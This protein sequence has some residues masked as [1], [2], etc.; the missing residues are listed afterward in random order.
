MMRRKERTSVSTEPR[1]T[2]SHVQT[3]KGTTTSVATK[4]ILSALIT[5]QFPS[6]IDQNTDGQHQSLVVIAGNNFKLHCSSPVESRFLWR[7]C[8]LGNRQWKIVYNGK[9]ITTT[10]Q[11]AAKVSVSHCGVTNC[12]FNVVNIQ[13]AGAG[14]FT[15]MGEPYNKYW[16]VTILSKYRLNYFALC[17]SL[18]GH[19]GTWPST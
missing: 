16:S 7:Y 1:T 19:E 18:V 13:L 8:P 12:T 4:K 17:L 9:R 15:C 11:L 14:F 2:G 10:F 6:A 5:T 3:P